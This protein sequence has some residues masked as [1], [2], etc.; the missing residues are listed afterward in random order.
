M[1]NTNPA[2]GH[3]Q[4]SHKFTLE[5][6]KYENDVH[7]QPCV[8]VSIYFKKKKGVSYEHFSKHWAQVHADLTVA[9]K[10]FGLFRVQRYTQHHQLPEMKAGLARIGMSAMDFD[11]CSTLWFKTWDD[12]EGFFTSPDYEGSLTEDCK[13]FMDL[14]GGLSVFA[15]H[16]VI[17]FGK[18]IPGVDDQNGITECPA[19]V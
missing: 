15:G 17:A 13:H 14:E 6:F 5:H 19:Y 11:G 18:G 10:N 2:D 1:A 7:Y 12:F 9:S 4:I 16:D 3:V 8:K